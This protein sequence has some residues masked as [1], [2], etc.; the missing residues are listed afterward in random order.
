MR[1]QHNVGGIR[2]LGPVWRE[3]RVFVEPWEE[4][5]LGIHVAMMGV[6]IWTWT[7]LRKKA[8]SM[9]PV[10]YF[11]ERYYEKWLGGIE[12]FLVEQG[13]LD[14]AELAERTREMLAADDGAA[15]STGSSAV[16][17]QVVDYLRKG[18]SPR[19]QVTAAAAFEVGDAVR[20]KIYEPWNHTRLPGMLQG[21]VGTIDVVYE[22]AYHLPE[23]GAD[24][25][26]AGPGPVY[27]VRFDPAELWGVLAEPSHAAVYADIWE[28]YLEPA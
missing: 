13:Y 26:E 2:G 22:G 16:T 7:D 4:R 23:A 20:P 14:S 28:H 6:G 17:A 8:E 24:G 12:E 1:V 21:K 19:R 10:Q 5:I 15:V 27:C 3:P 18:D 9:N 25:L 11:T